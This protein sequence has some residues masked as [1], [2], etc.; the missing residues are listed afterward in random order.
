ML[1]FELFYFFNMKSY[2]ILRFLLTFFAL[3]FISTS[4]FASE[5]TVW[6]VDSRAEV[7]RGDAKGVSISD[8]GAIVLAP[9]VAEVYSTGQSYVWSSAV[10]GQGNVYL[11]TGNDGKIFKID[12]AGKGALF[13]DSNELDVSA[14]AVGKDGAVYAGTS[15][16]GKVYRIAADGKAEVYFDPGDKY[17]WSLAVM[18]DGSL[19]VGTGENGK[20]YKVKSAGAT[21]ESALLF[22]S[23]EAHIIS[24]AADS[25]GNLY[26]G[27]DSNG[28]VLRFDP[29]GKPFA[30]LDV[31][32]REVHDLSVG[33]DGSVYALALSDS[34][35]SSTASTA[36]TAT[37]VSATP[38]TATS[39]TSDDANPTPTPARSRNDLNNVKSAVFRIFP[40]GGS[41]ILWSSTTVIGFSVYAHQ[42]GNGFLL[43]TS[44]KGRI[45]SITNDGRETL[46]LQTNEGQVSN[47]LTDG[48]KLLAASSNQGKLY[49]FGAE[50]NAEGSYESSVR[51]AKTSASWGR[52]WWTG[53]GNIELQTRSGNTEKP[54][55]TWSAWSMPQRDPKGGQIASPKARYFQWKATLRGAATLNDVSVSYLGK[56]IAPEVLSINVLPTNVG[57][58]ANMMQPSDPAIEAS[59]I[60]PADLGMPQ[61]A[62]IPP[63][64]FYQRGA[65]AFQWT[66]E[67]RNG[68]KMEYDIYYREVKETNFHLLKDSTKDTFYT[69]DGLTLP[70]GRYVFKIVASDALSNPASEAL[71]G[72]RQSEP[73]DID[74]TPPTVQV[75]GVPQSSGDKVRIVFQ[76]SESS[77][78]IERAEYSVDGSTWRS[79]Y[80][81]D[82]ISDSASEK[83]TLDIPLK[84]PGEYVVALRVFDQNGN[85]GSART[86]VKK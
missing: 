50:S 51:D 9:K 25:K 16:D 15:P 6:T 10:D 58:A 47:I 17:I 36:V 29:D 39:S 31:P 67:D 83:Y 76:A 20:L 69:L 21:P 34:A 1:V 23:S 46:L 24:L 74:N 80:S 73:V 5:P 4:T 43:G 40:D 54:D 12:A 60:D 65:R 42:T 7:L 56:N 3:V 75:V 22:D 70:D 13:Y 38:A 44:D 49:S 71:S 53:A 2:T 72:D 33:P 62:N 41:E 55:E 84:A 82:G 8:T 68:D 27:T 61:T 48:K 63:R 79:V 11:G 59:G 26:A 37:T 19:A 18:A 14:L 81:D 45:Y 28:V 85:A 78:I 64:R 57:L 35:S 30:M 86:I 52:V 32:L 77:G 66:A